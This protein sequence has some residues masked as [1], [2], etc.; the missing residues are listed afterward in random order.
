MATVR[1]GPDTL[2]GNQLG[3]VSIGHYTWHP[4]RVVLL[5]LPVNLTLAGTPRRVRRCGPSRAARMWRPRRGTTGSD[6]AWCPRPISERQ[7]Q[8]WT[9]R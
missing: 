9:R 4:S 2:S 5:V 1:R 8:N 6:S 7:R 3:N